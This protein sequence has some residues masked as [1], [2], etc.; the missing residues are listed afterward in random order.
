MFQKKKHGEK[1]HQSA[2]KTQE[3]FVW[4]LFSFLKLLH[5]KF[6]A[7]KTKIQDLRGNI[8]QNVSNLFDNQELVQ[9]M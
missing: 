6:K 1:N 2:V 4:W 5:R 9:M 3:F 7:L 8:N